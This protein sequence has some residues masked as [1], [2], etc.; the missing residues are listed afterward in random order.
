VTYFLEKP[1]Q[2]WTRRSTELL[3]SVLLYADYT[4]PVE[5][6]RRKLHEILQ[7]SSK[8]DRRVWAL[9]V[10]NASDR[11]L[12]LRALMSAADSASAFDLRCEVRE[13]LAAFIQEHYPQS[14]P[15]NRTEQT[16]VTPLR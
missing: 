2:N 11:C 12:E 1:F 14:L 13:K 7:A 16:T 5:E 9:Q 8:W 10:T 6:V 3:G 4:I 15:K